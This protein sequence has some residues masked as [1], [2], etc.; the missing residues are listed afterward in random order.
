MGRA[1]GSGAIALLWLASCGGGAEPA[2]GPRPAEG[3]SPAPVE[4]GIATFNDPQ[5]LQ[6]ERV[7]ALRGLRLLRDRDP[8]AFRR[9]YDR[10]KDRL[11][12]DA[13]LADGLGLSD[14][15]LLAF[16]EAIGWLGDMKDSR[17]RLKMELHLDR[18]T[19]R[20]KRLPET[21]LAEVAL[22]LGKFPES[23]SARETL[24]AALKDPK[25]RT[26]VR[27][28]AMKAL[29]SHHPADLE[30]RLLLIPVAPGDD[31]LR[32]LQSKLR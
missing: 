13:S 1:R 11:W 30:T 2:A 31:W 18:E 10:I 23:E 3:R 9:T 6:A 20:R 4:E 19:V 21:A 12:A 22:G 14:L 24:W 17:A 15:E 7:E 32:D 26:V 28:S 5:K 29:Q 27:S 16:V 25:E 8:V